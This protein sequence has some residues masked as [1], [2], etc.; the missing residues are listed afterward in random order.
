MQSL[1]VRNNLCSYGITLQFGVNILDHNMLSRFFEYRML[2]TLVNRKN[3]KKIRD[4]I[5]MLI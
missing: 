3:S 1:Q 4:D 5:L 2:K